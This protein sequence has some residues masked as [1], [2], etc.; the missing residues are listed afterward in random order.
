[1]S[2]DPQ[3]RKQ[4]IS[5]FFAQRKPLRVCLGCQTEP[6]LGYSAG[7]FDP[8]TSPKLPYKFKPGDRYESFTLYCPKCGFSVSGFMNEQAV[9]SAWHR[10]NEPNNQFY[11]DRWLEQY[12][13]QMGEQLPAA[14]NQ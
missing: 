13:E 9:L 12:Q 10:T 3:Q 14:A 1:M 11:A 7:K 4:Q 5:E 2:I 6:R 8:E